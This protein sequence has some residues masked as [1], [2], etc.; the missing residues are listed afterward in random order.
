M[1]RK[2]AG[3]GKGLAV[4]V[5]DVGVVTDIDTVDA[6]AQ[7]EARWLQRQRAGAH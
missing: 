2:W 6:L 3:Q 7:A 1:V 4:P 5:E